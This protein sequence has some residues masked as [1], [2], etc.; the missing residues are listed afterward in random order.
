[1]IPIVLASGSAVRARL[2]TAAGVRFDI[3]PAQIDEE[4]V[5]QSLLAENAA[6]RRIAD[7]LAE[8]KAVTVSASRPHAL[9]IGADQVLSFQREI[10]SKSANVGE[11]GALLRRLAGQTHQLISAIVLAKAGAPLWH[12]EALA[13][14]QM[15]EFSNQFLEE[16]LAVENTSLLNC[17]GCYHL[18]GRGAQLFAAIRGDYFSILGL[19]LLPLLAAL[20]EFGALVA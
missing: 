1:M 8:L 3:V 14:L 20:R 12:H 2:L 10:I 18:E 6:P 7:R 9:V 11:A 15:R 4:A 13:E 19:P 16:Y 5:K 17:V